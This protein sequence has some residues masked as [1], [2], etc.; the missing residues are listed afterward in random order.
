LEKRE[1]NFLSAAMDHHELLPS[2]PRSH[3]EASAMLQQELTY[4]DRRT[5]FHRAVEM[6]VEGTP[7]TDVVS[8]LVG[9]GIEP[10]EAEHVV[11]EIS[12]KCAESDREQG[13]K[14]IVYGALWF[15][16]GL[17]VT[18]GSY[19]LAKNAGGG[20]YLVTSGALVWGG[21]QFLYGVYQCVKS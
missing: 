12:K 11:S 13:Q 5:L 1:L 16:G 21:V 8:W 18:L 3:P 4:E 6:F 2:M 14:N 20:M 17:V 15:I 7:K 10:E 9:G 19:T